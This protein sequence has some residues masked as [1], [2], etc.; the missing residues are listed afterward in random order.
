MERIAKK[1]VI[2]QSLKFGHKTRVV[3]LTFSLCTKMVRMF[4]TLCGDQYKDFVLIL[5]CALTVY[6]KV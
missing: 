4:E 3:N 1:E 5:R 2:A 6:R